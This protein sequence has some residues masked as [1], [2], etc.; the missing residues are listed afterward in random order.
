MLRV[1]L[2]ICRQGADNEEVWGLLTVFYALDT[3]L[4]VKDIAVKTHQTRKCKFLL[5]TRAL[6]FR[7]RMP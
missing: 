4:E 7:S 6:L 3:Q 5:M 2:K 1:T